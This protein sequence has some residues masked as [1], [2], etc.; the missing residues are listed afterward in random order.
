[1]AAAVSQQGRRG[2]GASSRRE[3][4]DRRSLCIRSPRFLIP[5]FYS[6]L[7]GMSTSTPASSGS[8]APSGARGQVI[9][10]VVLAVALGLVRVIF[11]STPIS[12]S[13]VAAIA[14]AFVTAADLNVRAG[15]GRT[16]PVLAIVGQGERVEILPG[17]APYWARIRVRGIEGWASRRYLTESPDGQDARTSAV[18]FVPGPTRITLQYQD[19]VD[20]QTVS[21][22][23]LALRHHEGWRVGSAEHILPAGENR[24]E[25][26]GGVRYFFEGDSVLAR[27]VCTGVQAELARRGY[28][29]TMPLWPMVTRQRLG[30]FNARPG[31]IEV[32][33]S[34]L[35]PSAPSGEPVP[36]GQCGR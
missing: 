6:R 7:S 31:L 3:R 14:T 12:G 24:A 13:P 19:P 29:V 2:S 10:W 34:P 17:G 18:P 28:T 32:W 27:V 25:T 20:R 23:R 30:L 16:G 35:P 5:S 21:R 9:Q 15:P 1:M 11:G 33:I 26:Y 4:R 8:S 22:V 36:P